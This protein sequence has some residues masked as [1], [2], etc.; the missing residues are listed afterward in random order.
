MHTKRISIGKGKKPKWIT[1]P[2]PGRHKRNESITLR[3]I[4]RDILHFADTA[5]EADIL[6]TN[7]NIL[8]DK[9]PR[10]DPRFAVGLMDIIEIP[11]I[12]KFYRVLPN[13]KGLYLREIDKNEA[14]LKPCKITKKVVI[15]KEKMQIGFHDSTTILINNEEGKKFKIKDTVVFELPDMKIHSL[16][17]LKKGNI[18]LVTHGVHAGYISEISEITESTQM[19]R[20]ITKIGEI[21]TLTD[22]IFVIGEKKPLISC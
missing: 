10:K 8:V 6:I 15:S 20:S 5:R 3:E 13:K 9:K 21:Q 12:G 19:K 7:G 17:N 1:T 4:V 18:G 14:N 16:L 22:Y 11:K 2:R